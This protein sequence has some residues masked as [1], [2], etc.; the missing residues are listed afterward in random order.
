MYRIWHEVI[1]FIYKTMK[2]WRVELTAGGRLAEAKIQRGIFQGDALSLLLFTIAMRPLNYILRK[3]TAGYKLSRLR[4][5]NQSPNAH[6]WH[7]TI[8][9]IE[10]ELE[11]LIHAVRIYSQDIG[12]EFII[13]K[14]AKR[15]LTEW[16][17]QIK[18]RLERSQ[19]TKPTIT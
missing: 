14:C 4:E 9:K 2:T 16:N 8:S 5:K 18:T 17:Y 15:H 19:K 6:G 13:E 10:K 7:Q 12:M 1:N 11:T 3:C